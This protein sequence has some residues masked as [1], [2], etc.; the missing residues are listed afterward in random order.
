MSFL[1][2]PE[3]RFSS[4]ANSVRQLHG[5]NAIQPLKRDFFSKLI[6]LET[7]FYSKNYT[8]TTLDELIQFYAVL[9]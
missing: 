9:K 5:E 4:F 8:I 1:E 7:D 6:K 2:K 3:R